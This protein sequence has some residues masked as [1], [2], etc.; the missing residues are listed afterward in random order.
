M[1]SLRW[2]IADGWTITRRDLLHWAREPTPVIIGLLFPVMLV[3]TFGYLFGGAMALPGG[4]DYTDFLLPGMFAMT[5]L[6][7]MEAT[8]LAVNTDAARGVTDRFRSMPM[9]PSAVVV[10]RCGAD[11]LNS[12]A[13]LTVIMVCGV[14]M[15]WRATGSVGATVAGI[16]LLLLLRFSMLWIGVFLGLTIRNPEAIGAL[17]I[18]IWPFTFLSNAFVAPGTMPGWL[19]TIAEWNPLSSTAAG[20]RELFGNPSWAGNSWIAQNAVLMA[21]VWPLLIVAVFFPLSVRRYQ[22]LGR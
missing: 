20:V 18:V 2:A 21:V 8:M 3:L 15:G 17:Q 1:T 12:A 19:G 16:G 4:A 11:M 22:R 5:M 14:A 7:G 6:F 9:A 13:S 10:G